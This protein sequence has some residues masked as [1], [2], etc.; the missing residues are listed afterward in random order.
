MPSGAQSDV[1][2]GAPA[3]ER[4][5]SSSRDGMATQQDRRAGF[6]RKEQAE[7][8]QEV[9][10]AMQ[11]VQKMKADPRLTETLQRAK[12]VFLVPRFGEG[13]LVVGA[14][15]GEGVLVARDGNDWS[16]PVFYDFGG[17]TLGAQAGG[18]GGSMALILM[19]D[20]AVNR[21]K[22][23]REFSL[24]ADAG[25]TFGMWSRRGQASAGKVKDVIVWSDTKG[26]FAGASVG[27]SDIEWDDDANQAYYQKKDVTT[28]QILDGTVTNPHSNVLQMVLST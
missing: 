8:R 25:V 24:N 19:T 22:S 4:T 7:A 26:A 12:G 1:T 3:Q 16:N 15:G 10:K 14:Q 23:D 6:D 18:A 27:I 11:V 17:L 21:F 2:R 9:T 13:A 28:Q 20:E 5:Q